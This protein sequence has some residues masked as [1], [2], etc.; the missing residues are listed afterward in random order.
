MGLLLPC[1]ENSEIGCKRVCIGT[2]FLLVFSRVYKMVKTFCGCLN[3]KIY[4]KGELATSM[5]FSADDLE[6]EESQDIFF[7]Q[8]WHFYLNLAV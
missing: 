5:V 7:Q 2:D 8:V 6:L 1:V 3:V 4:I